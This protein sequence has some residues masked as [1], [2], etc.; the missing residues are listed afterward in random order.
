[1]PE[2]GAGAD[3]LLSRLFQWAWRQDENFTTE[4]FAHLQRQL[5][6]LD[7][8][9]GLSLLSFLTGDSLKCEA[10]RASRIEIL[11]QVSYRQGRPDIEI[12]APEFLGFVEVK[13]ESSEGENQLARY[14]A[15]L[16]DSG[17]AHTCLVYLTRYPPGTIS[18]GA[19]TVIQRRW[20]EIAQHLL[21]ALKKEKWQDRE[22]RFLA[23]Q[24]AG[25]LE[26]RGMAIQEV[27]WELERG[28]KS[29]WNLVAM[30][31]EA[32]A[33][34]N[35]KKSAGWEY[36]GFYIRDKKAWV[37]LWWEE[38]ARL[39][40]CTEDLDVKENA[41]DVVGYGEMDEGG[42]QIKVDIASE[43]V[44]F[45]ARSRSSQL[46]CIED[47]VRRGLGALDKLDSRV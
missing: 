37:G 7:P 24:F 8:A 44:H 3:N 39:Y 13:D 14:R 17:V 38:P 33:K 27:T 28:V 32:V 22:A 25:Y 41:P 40:F 36:A 43:D 2:P 46:K 42:W 15:I 29:V 4:A 12:R 23:G 6:A 20:H 47:F 31:G 35:P 19:G 5:L 10:E 18:E 26:E 30:I 11:T 45:F 9:R 16:N 21:V 34:E 1:M